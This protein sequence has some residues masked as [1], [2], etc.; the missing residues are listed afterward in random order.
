M[1]DDDIGKACKDVVTDPL[2]EDLALLIATSST[3]DLT[4]ELRKLETFFLH[5]QRKYF[6]KVFPD[7]L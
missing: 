6:S 3:A 5:G 4:K 7:T 2:T 1:I